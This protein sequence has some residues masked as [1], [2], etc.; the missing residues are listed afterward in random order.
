MDFQGHVWRFYYRTLERN[1]IQVQKAPRAYVDAE[2]ALTYQAGYLPTGVD[3][4][5]SAADVDYRTYRLSHVP[6]PGGGTLQMGVIAFGQWIN[7]TTFAE[8]ESTSGFTVAVNYSY[9]RTATDR[10]VVYGELHAVS[11]MSTTIVLN[12]ATLDATHPIE[13]MAV[14]GVS[15]RARAW[16]L[17]RNGVQKQLDV[18]TVFLANALGLLPTVR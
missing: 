11:P 5:V 6:A 8:A 14:N 13:V 4:V 12:H 1:N 9:W 18:E 17:G 15:A 7:A 16:W 3:P 10:R 2:T